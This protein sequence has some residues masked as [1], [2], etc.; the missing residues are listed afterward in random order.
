M[1]LFE[2]ALLSFCKPLS[3]LDLSTLRQGS[4]YIYIYIYIYKAYVLCRIARKSWKC[5]IWREGIFYLKL[6]KYIYI[7]IIKIL[8]KY[9][10]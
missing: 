5:D 7:Y 1:S 10:Y 9:D 6:L 3:K 4:I 2:S 8:L